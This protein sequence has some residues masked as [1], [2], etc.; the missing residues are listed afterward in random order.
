MTYSEQKVRQAVNK[1]L[2]KTAGWRE[3]KN[4][5]DVLLSYDVLVERSVKERNDPVYSNAIIP[6]YCTIL[7][8]AG[9]VAFIILP[10]FWV[11]TAIN[12]V[13]KRRNDHYHDARHEIQTKQ[14]GRD[15][16]RM[17]SNGIAI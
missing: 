8:R 10:N 15:G 13:S 4:N 14:F 5:P 3:V 6:E 12:E 11:M 16:R 2:G 1:E 9:T 7:T 17:K